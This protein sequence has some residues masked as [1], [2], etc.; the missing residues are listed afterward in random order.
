M[1]GPGRDPVASPT[2]GTTK[3]RTWPPQLIAAQ[4]YSQAWEKFSTGLCAQVSGSSPAAGRNLD[5]MSVDDDNANTKRVTFSPT[6][7]M[8][9]YIAP[10]CGDFFEAGELC[11]PCSELDPDPLPAVAPLQKV[12]AALPKKGRPVDSPLTK[13]EKA[14]LL[15]EKLKKDAKRHLFEKRDALRRGAQWDAPSVAERAKQSLYMLVDGVVELQ[16][17]A[18]EAHEAYVQARID[19]HVEAAVARAMCD[20]LAKARAKANTHAL[21]CKAWV[22]DAREL[23]LYRKSAAVEE[24]E[25]EV[26]LRELM[27]D[28]RKMILENDGVI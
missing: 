4:P 25:F 21:L 7:E 12:A 19:A 3:V 14:W 13:A 24:E 11:A 22:R 15:A 1:L 23:A 20:E 8:R 6:V 16:K 17:A 9:E 27:F 10:D 5:A 18:D 28:A 2:L 26:W